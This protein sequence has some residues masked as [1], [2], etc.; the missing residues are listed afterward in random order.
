MGMAMTWIPLG[1]GHGLGQLSHQLV[2]GKVQVTEYLLRRWARLDH[3]L[4]AEHCFPVLPPG[5]K[6]MG[7]TLL[8]RMG[9]DAEA[10]RH[11]QLVQGR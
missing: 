6:A 7:S 1:V 5:I 3:F 4:Q 9:S 11:A 2:P 8:V 10:V